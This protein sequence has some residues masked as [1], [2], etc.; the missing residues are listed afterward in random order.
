M[1]TEIVWIATSEQPPL[2]SRGFNVWAQQQ[3]VQCVGSRA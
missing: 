2:S 1:Q 3:G